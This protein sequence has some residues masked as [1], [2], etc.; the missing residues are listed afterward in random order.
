MGLVECNLVWVMKKG[1][2]TTEH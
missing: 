1:T 2:A